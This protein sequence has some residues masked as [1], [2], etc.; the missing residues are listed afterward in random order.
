MKTESS[1]DASSLEVSSLISLATFAGLM[2]MSKRSLQ[3]LLTQG[4]LPT[5]I[6]L[7]RCLRWVRKEVDD[8]IAAKCPDLSRVQKLRGA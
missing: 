2:N 7:G 1:K 6:R 5:P 4:K 3:R 8:W